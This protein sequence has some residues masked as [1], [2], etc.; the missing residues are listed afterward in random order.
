MNAVFSPFS[1]LLETARAAALDALFPPRCGGCGRFS[2]RV[3]CAICQKQNTLLCPPHCLICGHPFDP[4]AFST[5]LCFECRTQKP[6]LAVARAVW[7]FGGPPREAIHRLKYARKWALGARLAPFL[8]QILENDE[9]MRAFKPTLLVPVPLHKSRH[10]ARGFN[11]SEILAD[12]LSK[13]C[14]LPVASVLTRTRATPPQVGLDAAKRQLNVHDAFAVQSARDGQILQNQ[15]VL[16][17]DDVFTT[18]ATLHE[19]ARALQK[20]GA[21]QVGALTLAR[22]IHSELKPLF[23]KPIVLGELVTD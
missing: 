21:A 9:Q 15:R 10:K 8:S 4:L 22:Q 7:I 12:E 16:L 19:C 1:P 20:N 5:Q 13:L 3:F 18:G 23:Q 2:K 17:I 14:A 6:P 11:Q